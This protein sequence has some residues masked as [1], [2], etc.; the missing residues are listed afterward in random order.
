MQNRKI[1]QKITFSLLGALLFTG[2]TMAIAGLVEE[3]GVKGGIV[4]RLGVDSGKQLADLLVS[5]RYLV[6]GLEIDKKKISEA[7]AWLR[8]RGQYGKISVNLM[9]GDT[10]PYA[11][12]TVNLLIIESGKWQVAN[13]ELERVLVPG[14]VALIAGKKTV[15]PVPTNIDDWTHYLHGP[16][17]NAVAEDTVVS[18][19]RSIQWVSDPMWARS[20]E[21]LASV[22]AMVTTGGRVF[23][24]EDLAP[25]VSIR[26]MPDWKLTCRDAFNGTLLWQ[27]DVGLWTDHLRHFRAGPVHITRRLVAVDDKVYVTLALDAPVSV[28]DAATGDV[29]KVLKGSERTDEI[30]VQ[31]ETAFLVMGTSEVYREGAQGGFYERNEPKATKFRLI[32]A[33]NIEAN[34]ELWSKN[35]SADQYLLPMTMTVRDG[36]VYY[37]D[38]KGVGRLDAK[39]GKAHWRTPRKTVARR[40]SFAAPTVVATDEVLLVADRVPVEPV[41]KEMEHD[42]RAGSDKRK[43]RRASGS[44]AATNR[45]E[46]GVGGWEVKGYP[47][48]QANKLIAYSV[49]DG[50]ELWSMPANENYNAATDVFVIGDN[51]FVGTKWQG[52]NL[53]TGEQTVRIKS[54]GGKVG[55][56][57][58]RCYRNKASVNYIYTGRSGI[59]VVDI[60]KGW[61]ENNSWI[62][63]VCQYGIMPA[64]GLFYTPPNAC[65]CFTQ[66]KVRGFFVAGG[67][68]EKGGKGEFG[69]DDKLTK[70][71]AFG[72]TRDHEPQATDWP[73]YRANN[74]RG[75]A[76]QTD[77]AGILKMAWSVNVTKLTSTATRSQLTQ[78][79]IVGDNMY[80][81][82]KDAHT[83]HALST[84][85]GTKKWTYTTGG[86]IDSSPTFYKGMIIFGS[87]DGHVYCLRA[88]DGELVWKFRA[89]PFEMQIGAF[90]Q[91]ESVWPVHGSVLVHN[92]ELV[93]TAGRSTYLDGG[94]RF[95][96]LNPV[97]GKMLAQKVIAHI[98]PETDKQLGKEPWNGFNMEGAISDIMSGGDASV[99]LSYMRLD[100]DGNEQKHTETVNDHLFSITSMLAEE[101]FIRTYWFLGRTIGAGWGGWAKSASN[102]S[103]RIMAFD[104][105]GIYGYG[106]SKVAA[107]AT[108]HQADDYHLYKH[109][110]WSHKNSVI[111]RALVKAGDKLV[112]AG[113]PDLR[114][115]SKNMLAYD[116]EAE[117]LASFTGEKGVK[118]CIVNASDGAILSETVLDAM[119]AFDGLSAANGQVFIALKNGDVQ[120][121]VAATGNLKEDG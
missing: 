101:W 71:P 116:N 91:L 5:D 32:K 54:T 73:M 86:R 45:V 60:E 38:I 115:K 103:G 113:P 108:G 63:G 21:Q 110:G 97:T 87:K 50:K 17:N 74:K 58:H 121:W 11:D 62:R 85:D 94:L 48:N 96:R 80:I 117:A 64:N 98:D 111:A 65:A 8:A 70:G 51:V 59:E 112:V 104:E 36:S 3:S 119:P 49:E 16:D 67:K 39:T 7:R 83:I 90:A 15:K 53:K 120:C 40:L 9:A 4:V 106:R 41:K 47:R 56:V 72:K 43:R 12:N 100:K 10:L 46:W 118:M 93:F 84:K 55:M 57:H 92:D 6:Q 82:E 1:M 34:K 28:L 99:F 2:S 27:K 13:G 23:Y 14:G 26:Y 102:P 30:T 61:Q 76:V 88:G 66:V 78:P 81:A 69:L 77:V 31:D 25:R 33:I 89:A 19:P 68:R 114:K 42:G 24:I 20:H 44:P 22:S 95:Y 107:G 18:T 37:Q 75:S 52:F 109:R 35:F 79:V 29:I 105:N